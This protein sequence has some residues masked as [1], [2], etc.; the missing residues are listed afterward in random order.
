MGVRTRR[1]CLCPHVLAHCP[2][3]RAHR[4][5]GRLKDDLNTTQ[6][7]MQSCWRTS[8]CTRAVA[9]AVSAMIG[10]WG[11]RGAGAITW[12][13]GRWHTAREGLEQ[14]AGACSSQRQIG[15]RLGTPWGSAP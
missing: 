2:Y 6:R 5:L 8:C 9:V 11:R 7:G 13:A 4:R 15:G 14:L 12:H 3:G 1:A 10:T